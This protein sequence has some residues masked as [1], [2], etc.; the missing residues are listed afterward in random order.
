MRVQSWGLADST[1]EKSLDQPVQLDLQSYRASSRDD[2]QARSGMTTLNKEAIEAQWAAHIDKQMVPVPGSK[3]QGFTDIYKNAAFPDVPSTTT[4]YD[5]FL[6]GYSM[7]PNAPCLGHRPWDEA[8]GD[9]A[10]YFQWRTYA[11]TETERTALGSAMSMWVEKGMLNSRPNE[12]GEVDEPGMI[13]FSVAYWGANRPEASVVALALNAYSRCAISLYDNYDA[14]ISCYILNHSKS[15]VLFTT[16]SYVPLVLR[17]ADK[18]PLLRVLV[19]LD[20]PS[21]KNVAHGEIEKMQLTREWASSFG[22][23]TFSYQEAVEQGLSSPRP[24]IVPRDHDHV[25]ALCYTSGTTGLP[26]ASKVTTGNCGLGVEGLRY[27]VPDTKM[28]SISYLPLAHILEKGWELFII[29]QGGCIGYYSGSIDRLIEDLQILKPTALPSVPRVLNRIATQIEGQ[30]QAPGLKGF[31]LRRAVSTKLKNYEETGSITHPIWDRLVFRK[32]RAMLGGRISVVFTGSAPCRPDVLKLLRVA[33][34]TDIREAYGQTENSAYA[35]FMAPH[36]RYLG[37][38]GPVNPGLEV[39]LRDCP[40]L[41]YTSEDKPYPRGEI[42][43]RGNTVFIG[44]DG[45]EKKTQETL[46]EGAD[47]HGPWLLTGDVGQIDEYNRVQIIDRVKNLVKLAQGEYIAIERVEGVFASLPLAQQLW[48]YGDSYQP[49]L[50]AVC[51]PEPEPFAE[52]ASRIMKHKINASDQKALEEAAANSAVV[53]AVLREFISLGKRQKL[54]TLEQ[55]RGLKLRMEPFSPENGLMTP[56]LKVK[57]QEAAKL[58][59]GDLDE[60]Y[61]HPPYDLSK[62][63]DS[64]L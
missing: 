24:H 25:D 13:D 63:N 54:G 64:K 49:H 50:V 57:R 7:D 30:L 28:V 12:K 4:A 18:L 52:F 61:S 40:E 8:K 26:K 38:V 21:P 5:A 3:E 59:K 32:V 48:L 39:R 37:S 9:L 33:L 6:K 47:G 56:T 45:D 27:V 42:L 22:I 10:D 11:D 60:L 23:Q 16:S 17:S 62:V 51:V 34:C 43:F 20:Q 41:G 35:T 53:E 58:L 36:D 55:M 1:L 31:L 14:A 29:R 19:I 44:Y 2:F 15:R 46:L